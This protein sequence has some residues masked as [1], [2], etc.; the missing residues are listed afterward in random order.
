MNFEVLRKRAMLAVTAG[1]AC[2]V[3]VGVVMPSPTP[4]E[5]LLGPPV[6]SVQHTRTATSLHAQHA[7]HKKHTRTAGQAQSALAPLTAPAA[8]VRLVVPSIHLDSTVLPIDVTAGGVLDPPA[9]T[10]EV[11]WWR[12]SAP[13]GAHAGQTVLT[14]HTVH[15]GGGV[16]NNLGQIRPGDVVEVV[17]AEG[18]MRYRTEVVRDYTK[19][20]LAQSAVDLF[21]QDR[22]NGRLV[23][24]TC[25]GWTGHDYTSNTVVT[26]TPAGA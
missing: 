9:D 2:L 26:A 14:G 12:E 3:A 1:I 24:V 15:T 13:P 20:E 11:G 19:A 18:A 4:P 22:S 8:P 16:M 6:A 10:Q 23:L 5:S 7:K 25:T 21:G 17:T